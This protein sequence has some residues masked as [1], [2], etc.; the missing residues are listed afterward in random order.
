M[1]KL[2]T[3]LAVSFLLVAGGHA[4]A[5]SDPSDRCYHYANEMVALGHRARVAKCPAQAT[6]HMNWDGHYEWCQKQPP[7]RTRQAAQEWGA[8]FDG[9]AASGGVSAPPAHPVA[10]AAPADRATLIYPDVPGAS[11]L[12]LVP[13]NPDTRRYSVNAMSQLALINCTPNQ[14]TIWVVQRN[15]ITVAGRPDLCV[16]ASAGAHSA[17]LYLESCKDSNVSGWEAGG[18]ATQSARLR[19]TGGLF[20][21]QCLSVPQLNDPANPRLPY[22]V[23]LKSCGRDDLKFFVE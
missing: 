18:N 2:S 22:T 19:I 12:C 3:T 6:Q 14:G 20:A 4:Q 10:P 17:D 11:Q 13:I 8:R 7:A 9:C 5:Q 15:R 23:Q 21:N 16:A 1:P